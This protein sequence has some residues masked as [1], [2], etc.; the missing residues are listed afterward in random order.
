MLFECSACSDNDKGDEEPRGSSS[1]SIFIF[2]NKE[3]ESIWGIGWT[4]LLLLG[5]VILEEGMAGGS[6]TAMGTATVGS[7]KEGSNR[8]VV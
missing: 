1:P 4:S 7:L 5:M 8:H 2:T 3:E 6:N